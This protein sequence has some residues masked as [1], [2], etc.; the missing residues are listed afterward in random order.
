MATNSEF[1][2]YTAYLAAIRNATR[3]IWIQQAY[4]APNPELR[5]ELILAAKRGVDIRIIVPGFTDSRPIYYASR[6]TY[7]ELL[8]SGI[9]LYEHN[10]ALLHAKTP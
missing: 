1:R 4:F 10:E 9:S 5:Q 7:G 6:A 2:I 8:E 3:K